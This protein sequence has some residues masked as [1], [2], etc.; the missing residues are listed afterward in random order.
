MKDE[1]TEDLYHIIFA[2]DQTIY[3]TLVAISL[4]VDK[5]AA[6]TSGL[7]GL[8]GDAPVQTVDFDDVP[9]LRQFYEL[10]NSDPTLKEVEPYVEKLFNIIFSPKFHA[11]VLSWG[12]KAR[13]LLQATVWNSIRKD[14]P[15]SF[16]DTDPGSV[17]KPPVPKDQLQMRM[18]EYMPD[19]ENSWWEL[20]ARGWMPKVVPQVMVRLCDNQCYKEERRPEKFGEVSFGDWDYRRGNEALLM[21]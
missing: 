7:F 12:K 10:Y 16:G 14:E 11:A 1:R 13:W 6:L 8:L 18:D 3:L 17:W 5:A 2:D 21:R 4:H 20:Y 9:R 19:E 15:E